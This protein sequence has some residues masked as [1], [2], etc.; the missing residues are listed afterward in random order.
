MRQLAAIVLVAAIHLEATF[1]QGYDGTML[2]F[3][4]GVDHQQVY[5]RLVSPVRSAGFV[6]ALDLGA[7]LHTGS[8]IHEV[9]LDCSVGEISNRYG[10]PAFGAGIH[11]GY[12]YRYTLPSTLGSGW[13]LD[14][15][16]RLAWNTTVHF[17]R[18]LDEAH[19]YWLTATE[20]GPRATSRWRSGEA[21]EFSIRLGLPALALVSRPPAQRY[22][23]NDQPNPGDVLDLVHSDLSVQGPPDYLGLDVDAEYSFDISTRLSESLRYRGS[24][25]RSDTPMVGEYLSHSFVIFIRYRL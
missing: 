13:A 6:T 5:D 25:R 19:L 18:M 20:L 17:H 8:S 1:G 9:S 11:L 4:L 10:L 21:G 14:L 2:R 24:Y 12:E 22:Y 23:N 15:G 7:E 16:G 3:G